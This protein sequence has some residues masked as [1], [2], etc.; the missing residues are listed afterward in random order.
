LKQA[1]HLLLQRLEIEAHRL[2]R[3]LEVHLEI[4]VGDDV[5]HADDLATANHAT[6][7]ASRSTLSRRRGC[8]LEAMT[9]ST[10]RPSI[11]SSLLRRR[12]YPTDPATS[13]NSTS[14]S[15]SPSGRASPRA[16]E[17]NKSRERTPSARSSSAC[18]ARPVPRE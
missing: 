14:R 11:S 12:T 4:A 2:P 10:W 3:H 9:R 5:P 1:A 13:S 7:R 15:T 8:R 6:C 18:A 16:T 17:P